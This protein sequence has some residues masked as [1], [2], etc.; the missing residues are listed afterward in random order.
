MRNPNVSQRDH[1]TA[2]QSLGHRTQPYVV[3]H[4]FDGPSELT[5]TLA[6]AIAD[7]TGFDVTE[8]G[9]TLSDYV[10]PAALDRL[11]A[12]KSDGTPRT[13]GHLGFTI[14][15]C[16]VTVYSTG[17]IVVTQTQPQN[18]GRNQQNPTPR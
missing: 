10:D 2:S 8:T 11:F 18:G 6:H 7:V 17:Q 16:Q 3:H 5:T 9:F 15:D 14:W 1:A 4:D 13:N 12:P